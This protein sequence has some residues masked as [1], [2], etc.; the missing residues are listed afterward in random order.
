MTLHKG[1]TKMEN[2]S[3]I[4]S[5][6]QLQKMVFDKI[7]FNRTGFKNEN[8]PKFNIESNFMQS[9]DDHN[10][11]KVELVMKCLKEDEYNFEIKLVGYFSFSSD[12]ELDEGDKDI[13]IS[14]NSVA[15]LMPYMRSQISLLTAQPEMDCIV[16][17]PF[18]I[19]E[20]I[21]GN[22]DSEDNTEN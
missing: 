4:L 11:F 1:V 9:T 16:L 12:G 15:I 13:L 3:K 21:D 7:E 5:S 19:N 18:N 8:N 22:N 14:R 6:L 10:L 20:M 2:Q 17:P